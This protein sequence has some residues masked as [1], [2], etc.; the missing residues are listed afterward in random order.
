MELGYA[1]NHSQYDDH[2]LPVTL[3]GCDY[4][5]LSWTLGVFQMADLSKDMEDGYRNVLD[6]WGYGFDLTKMS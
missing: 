4:E 5:S 1:L 6:T 2:I 3:V